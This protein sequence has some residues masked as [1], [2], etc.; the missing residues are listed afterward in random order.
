MAAWRCIPGLSGW[1]MLPLVCALASPAAS[2][3]L[4][5]DDKAQ[6]LLRLDAGGAT[7]LARITRKSANAL[8]IH[9]GSKVYAQ[10]KTV[11]LLSS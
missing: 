11:A 1:R 7:L 10:I 5:E 8:D 4:S 2:A 9:P 6:I 3:A